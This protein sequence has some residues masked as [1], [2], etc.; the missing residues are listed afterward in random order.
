V[1]R[2]VPE[3]LGVEQ[4]KV[5]LLA[6]DERWAGLY[7]AEERRLREAI[8]PLIVAIEHFGSTSIPGIKAKPILDI[9][10]G[11][12]RFEDGAKLVEPLAALGYDYVG[13]E[14]VPDDHLFGLG[15]PRRH[16]LHAVQYGGYH[17]TRDLRFRDRLRADPALASSYEALKVELAKRFAEQRAEYTAA[18]KAFIDSIADG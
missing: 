10:V 3:P 14:M 1:D 5:R 9:L 16:L 12:P 15:Q 7:D 11:L 8:G 17:W 13:V 4:G 6:S 2:G 18:K